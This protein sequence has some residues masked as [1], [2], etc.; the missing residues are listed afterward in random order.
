MPHDQSSK[1]SVKCKHSNNNNHNNNNCEHSKLCH[2][3]CGY[4]S[5]KLAFDLFC[6]C[7]SVR[8]MAKI[9]QG[10]KVLRIIFLN[11]DVSVH[12]QLIMDNPSPFPALT[13]CHQPPFSYEAYKLW[14]QSK[15]LSPSQYNLYMRKLI[16]DALHKNDVN[17]ASSIWS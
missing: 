11:Y 8:G 6:S 3:S 17:S 2:Q 7:T 9:R 12:T 13:V 14:N 1:K 5:P 4:C 16:L 10:P 15:I